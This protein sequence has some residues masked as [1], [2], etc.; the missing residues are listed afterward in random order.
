MIN[1]VTNMKIISKKPNKLA[2]RTQSVKGTTKQL[3]QKKTWKIYLQK[4]RNIQSFEVF[5]NISHLVWQILVLSYEFQFPT[6]FSS[7]WKQKVS[8]L[9]SISQLFLNQFHTSV[10]FYASE[11]ILQKMWYFDKAYGKGILAWNGLF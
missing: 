3:L 1:K 4:V 11:K 9:C 8:W 5:F 2:L 6:D 7:S 10:P